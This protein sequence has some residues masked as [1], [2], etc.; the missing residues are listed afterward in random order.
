MT[1]PWRGGQTAVSEH[2][3]PKRR[4]LSILFAIAV[5]AAF[6]RAALATDFFASPSGS[7]SGDGTIGNPWSLAKAL[8]Q[9]ATVRP[10]DTIWLR[11]GTYDGTFY[12]S[13]NGSA[14]APIKVRQYPGERAT[15]DG[16]NS[17]FANIL[18]VAGSYT[19]YWGFEIMSSDP[20]HSSAQSGSAP[21]DLG[22]GDGVAIVQNSTTGA[23]LK[24]INL[25]IHDT[26]GGFGLWQQAYGAEIY[27][28]LIYNNGWTA[29]D[30]GHGHG[31]Y[32]QNQT[33]AKRI[34]NN[35]IFSNYSHGIHAYSTVANLNNI[36]IEGNTIFNN[37]MPDYARNILVGG[38][39]VAQNPSISNNVL[40]YPDASGENL[41]VGYDP[42]GMG[43]A[44]P[45]ITGNTIVMGNERFSSLN[46]NVT[47]TGNSFYSSAVPSA[48]MS[49]YPS[50][51]YSSS[52]PTTSQ[53]FVSPNQYEAGR[54][55]I[56]ILNW[57]GSSSVSVSLSGIV[58]PGASYEVR[59]AQDF[60]GAPVRSGVFGGGSISLPAYGRPAVFVV[61]TAASPT[62]PPP[63]QTP[64][65]PTTTP[66][67]PSP[68]PGPPTTTPVQPSPTP[69]PPTTTPIWPT[70]T[71]VP[72]IPTPPRPTPTP[73]P[74]PA[75]AALPGLT[76]PVAAHVSG[77]GGIV[78]VTD[79][80]IENTRATSVAAQLS[81]HPKGGGTPLQI[82]LTL[83]PGEVR[84]LPDV[85]ENFGVVSDL[86][87][88]RLEAAGTPL[89]LRMTSRTYDQIGDGTYG[90]AVTG[91][92][93]D[94]AAG[95]RFVT[96]LAQTSDFRTNL[97]AVNM[98]SGPVT[99]IIRLL[100]SDGSLVG[101][102]I[103]TLPAGA[104]MQWPLQQ[105]FPTAS[106]KGLTA[107]FRTVSGLSPVTYAAVADNLSGDPTY[108]SATGAASLIYLPVVAR[109]HGAGGTLYSSDVSVANTSGVPD[110][111]TATFLQ[112]DLENASPLTITFPIGPYATRQ[113]DDVLG[114]LFELTDAYGS[115]KI[116]TSGDASV[117]VSE[118]ISTPSPTTPGTVGQQVEPVAAAGFFSQCSLLGLRQDGAFRTNVGLFNPHPSDVSVKLV[119][120]TEKGTLLATATLTVPAGRYVQKNL[121]TL[122]PATL[123]PDGEAMSIGLN[124]VNSSIF[125][126]ASVIDNVS[127]DPTFYPGLP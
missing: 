90:Q 32:V 13:L 95:S 122:F 84:N 97:G 12:A 112:S 109:V 17:N 73:P 47:M 67:Q 123:F 22:I 1:N 54:A 30:R 74:T 38:S 126:F 52:T 107:E 118:R 59:D 11:G 57:A 77:V 85:L 105:L 65:P 102:P 92:P 39:S 94:S 31:I 41:N 116:Q 25:V 48:T 81:F 114:E 87:A 68:T 29:P 55:N 58:A 42:S 23:G 36:D 88:L 82:P 40:Y 120:K 35:V 83:A 108:Y 110:V 26:A 69:R 18:E 64:P 10:G 66:V 50:N 56:T 71:P 46:T 63:T 86:G 103:L 37:G 21:T 27:G 75:P 43:A 99:L 93:P 53:V 62:A 60:F 113:M 127:Q 20:N 24:F 5:S 15:I 89:G 70:P 8:S 115:L 104:Q 100:A 3:V 91:R 34:A 44:N 14:T 80:H 2:C 45:V 6:T 79:L 76:I 111:V 124:T 49:G 16:G 117:M 51:T 96:G 33:S 98:T 7:A 125:A 106:G 119:L 9:P 19:Y 101:S 4:F 28:C 72:P 78:F 61:L 121:A